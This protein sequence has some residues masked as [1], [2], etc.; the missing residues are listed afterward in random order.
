M[1][2]KTLLKAGATALTGVAALTLVGSYQQ[3]KRSELARSEAQ[4]QI[5][6]TSAGP[7]E[8]AVE[9]QGPAMLIIHGSPGGYDHGIAL[10]RWI[11]SPDFT[12]IAPSRPG[13]LRT[14]L[15]SGISPEAQADL[16]AALLDTL[17][18]EQAVILGASGGGPSAL[19]FVLRH[20]ERCRGLVTLCAV[21]QRYVENEFYQQLPTGQRL[22][23][24]LTNELIFFDPFIYFL[25]SIVGLQAIAGSQSSRLI[26]TNVLASLSLAYLRKEGYRNDM[27]QFSAMAP[28]PLEKI[29]VPTFI[30]QGTAD[31]ELP[32]ADAQLLASKIPH[33]Q[34]VPV[35]GADHLFFLTH[36]DQV[37][38]ALR[39]FLHTLS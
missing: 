18:I 13:Y 5:A 29:T 22:L 35:P 19:Q 34:F 33:A 11:K 1:K 37:M 3:W 26:E 10:A 39:D 32:F 15:H 27:R 9:G 24:Q 25:Q 6:T 23:K 17:T 2:N 20:P 14:P 16:Y 36:E 38:P 7:I 30:S 4:S 21:S 28:Y 8:Y 12:Y 31:T